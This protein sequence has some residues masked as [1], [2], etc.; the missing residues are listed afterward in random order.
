MK[1]STDLGNDVGFDIAGT[2]NPPTSPT[3]RHGTTLYRL[4]LATGQATKVGDVATVTKKG[5]VKRTVLT[6]LAAVQDCEL[7]RKPRPLGGYVDRQTGRQER[8]PV[9]GSGER[10][11]TSTSHGPRDL[12]AVR[13]RRPRALRGPQPHPPGAP[14]KLKLATVANPPRPLAAPAAGAPPCP[15]AG[16][17]PAS[18]TRT[19]QQS[20]RRPPGR[21]IS[22]PSSP[23]SQT[24]RRPRWSARPVRASSSRSSWPTRSPSS[25]S[26]TD[27]G[28]RPPARAAPRSARSRSGRRRAHRAPPGCEAPRRRGRRTR[29]R[30]GGERLERQQSGRRQPEARDHGGGPEGPPP[31]VAAQRELAG[32]L[33]PGDRRGLGETAPHRPPCLAA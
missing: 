21:T 20:T 13:E 26:A 14:E 2:A 32:A 6:G 23:T 18:P 33:P 15:P 1:I 10:P 9:A 3:G 31:S 25:P 7:P 27:S 28:P 29:P 8:R 24:P 19:H 11:A 12:P 16:R 5:K 22:A 17:S 4:D 30:S